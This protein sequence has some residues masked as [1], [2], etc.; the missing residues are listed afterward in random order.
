M[1]LRVAYSLL[2]LLLLPLVLPRLAWRARRQPAYLQHVGERFGRYTDAG[3]DRSV[4]IHAV[5]VGETRAAEPLVRAM[6]A[7]YPDHSIVLSHMTPT[8]RD[9]SAT[10]FG[11]EARVR[12]VYLPYDAG[13]LVGRFLDHF[14]PVIGIVMETELWPN[15]LLGC[16][17]RGIPVVLA[18]ARLSERSARRYARWPALT[19]MTLGAISAFGAQTGDDAERLRRLGANAPSVTGNIKF[20]IK[21]PEALLVLG[22]AFRTRFGGRPVVLAASTR[23][24]EETLILDAFIRQAPASVLL[25]LVPRH[26]QRFDA[27]AQLVCERGLTLQMRSD[28]T[29]VDADTR[30]WLGDSMGEMF[31]YYAGADIALIGGS[32]LPFGG[33]NLIEAC[34][35]GTPVIIGP[36]TF[37][38]SLV[39]D[40]AVDCGAALRSPDA[41]D[42]IRVALD[43]L[44]HPDV[45]DR[46]GSA[47][48]TFAAAHRGATA[49]TIEI[50]EELMPRRSDP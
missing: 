31:A 13:L 48:Q 18:N 40:Q 5:S 38:F 14:R 44:A 26:P 46:C 2:W 37:N 41:D 50:I 19:R 28:G 10:L 35:V 25:A 33:Q 23:D 22:R 4:W 45:R 29:P 12:T 34:A 49:R 30:V 39:A 8:G 47:G 42:A 21:P 20:D 32:W 9:T 16:Q 43:L 36:H 1:L 27:V 6:L 7:R 17:T 3:P 11:D 15:L 24:G